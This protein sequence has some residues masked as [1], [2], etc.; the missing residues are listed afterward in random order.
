MAAL[1]TTP[2]AE[3]RDIRPVGDDGT[4]DVVY[5]AG[6]G[7]SGSTLLSRLLNQLPGWLAL[8]EVRYFWE[9]GLQQNRACECGHPFGECP[10]WREVVAELR[11]IG[12][13]VEVISPADGYMTV[14]LVT[15]S[16]IR[17]ALGAREDIE[18]RFTKFAPDAVHLATEGPL[19]WSAHT[20][21]Q[22]ACSVSG[23]SSSAS[24]AASTSRAMRS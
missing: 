7:R 20:S 22:I 4:V 10:L 14:P 23:P 6:D 9:R 21:E 8:G 11:D 24:A 3:G 19:G 17:L 15:Y 16:E 13:V 12:C 18:A 1:D 2:R 5:I